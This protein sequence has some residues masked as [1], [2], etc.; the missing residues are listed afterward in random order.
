MP[1]E[2]FF[3]R[4]KSVAEQIVSLLEE[5]RATVDAALYR[6]SNP[7]LASALEDA[8]RR[9]VRIRLVLDREKYRR[10]PSTQDLLKHGA[11]TFKLL[12][13]HKGRGSKMHHKF[14]IL[15]GRRVV[16]GSYNWTL[17]SEEQNYENLVVLGEPEQIGPYVQEFEALWRDAWQVPQA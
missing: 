6:F 11:M 5:T 1:V 9:G 14:A 15:D 4:A 8:A 17:E 10:T 12:G 7:A 13:G 2:V 3:T 16:T